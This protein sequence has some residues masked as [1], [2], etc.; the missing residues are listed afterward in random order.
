MGADK[1]AENI[2]NA[3]KFICPN[4]LPKPKSLGF[5]WKKTSFGVHSPWVCCSQPGLS[6]QN[7]PCCFFS[8]L[9]YTSYSHC[10]YR[11]LDGNWKN[12]KIAQM[13]L[14]NRY[15]KFENFLTKSRALPD[16][17]V[18]SGSPANF[19]SP[20]SPKTGL[21]PSWTPDFYHL[22][23][24]GKKIQKK[25]QKKK[26]KCSFQNF[27]QGFFYL[28]IWSGIFWHKIC[29]QGPYLMRSNNL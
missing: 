23:K 5:R 19:Q 11:I 8:S 26:I 4:C 14:L 21:S 9:D 16:I 6:K 12:W 17:T 22:K 27:F 10:L 18:R 20:V 28:F 3:P 24:W 1:S 15:M 13:A 7:I 29:V 2:L 25:I